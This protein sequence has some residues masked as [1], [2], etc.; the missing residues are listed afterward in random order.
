MLR[1]HWAQLCQ[2]LRS[3]APAAVALFVY[4]LQHCLW[5][6]SSV[7]ELSSLLVTSGMRHKMSTELASEGRLPP[8]PSPRAREGRCR[9]RVMPRLL[10]C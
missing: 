7:G 3:A 9:P 6:A 8:P 5:E 10:S 1:Y 4:S 2:Q